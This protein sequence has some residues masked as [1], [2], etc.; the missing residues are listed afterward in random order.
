VYV[1]NKNKMPRNHF[2]PFSLKDAFSS[3][4]SSSIVDTSSEIAVPMT[5][6]NKNDDVVIVMSAGT[7]DDSGSYSSKSDSTCGCKRCSM[8][9]NILV[10][11]NEDLDK[12]LNWIIF[13][14]F[15]ILIVHVRSQTTKSRI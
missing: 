14:M 7:I 4:V 1:T 13:F 2:R 3:D 9:N 6:S 10:V 8:R 11:S 5:L 15:I 12:K